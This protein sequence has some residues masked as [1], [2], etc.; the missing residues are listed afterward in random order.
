MVAVDMQCVTSAAGERSGRGTDMVFRHDTP[1]PAQCRGLLGAPTRSNF[2]V[3]PMCLGS[4][5]SI[6]LTRN[7][8]QHLTELSEGL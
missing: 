5:D 8:S 6:K 3:T 2:V 7:E 1:P 4:D